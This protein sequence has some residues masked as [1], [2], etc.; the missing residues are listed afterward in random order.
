MRLSLVVALLSVVSESV[1]GFVVLSTGRQPSRLWASVKPKLNKTTGKYEA[2]PN[3][4]G[5]YPYGPVGSLLRH[6][7]NPFFKRIADS[8]GYEQ[9]VLDY[10]YLMNVDR[11]E[12]TGNMD[13]KLNNALDWTYQKMAEKKGKPKVDYTVLKVKDAILTSVWGLAITPTVVYVFYKAFFVR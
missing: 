5:Q 3:D 9:D 12:A 6:G 1:S 8:Q 11:S 13:A 4:D 10:M 2:S 7:P